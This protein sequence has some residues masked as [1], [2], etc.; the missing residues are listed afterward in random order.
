MI[1]ETLKICDENT[2]HEVK[3]DNLWNEKGRLSP[4]HQKYHIHDH[5]FRSSPVNI[6]LIKS[7]ER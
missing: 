2:D 7:I 3:N 6:S 5:A 4:K 1:A